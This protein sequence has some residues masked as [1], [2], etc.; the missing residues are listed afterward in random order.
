MYK[1]WYNQIFSSKNSTSNIYFFPSPNPCFFPSP[2]TLALSKANKI[3]K[4]FQHWILSENG[5]C[6]VLC[7]LYFIFFFPT[8][9]KKHL[10]LLKVSSGYLFY[11]LIAIKDQKVIVTRILCLNSSLHFFP[12]VLWQ[13]VQLVQN[14]LIAGQ[15][16]GL[17]LVS[18]SLIRKY[19]GDED[20]FQSHCFC[21]YQILCGYWV[22]TPKTKITCGRKER[23]G[24]PPGAPYF[25]I[26]SG[27]LLSCLLQS[28]ILVS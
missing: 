5:F 23:I 25:C 1:Q 13:D 2:L 16:V 18:F 26:A 21:S 15:L 4:S 8:G 22:T 27:L 20:N 7:I 6:L 28:P 19:K 3:I 17:L 14:N 11:L 9:W 10:R 24:Y 12:M